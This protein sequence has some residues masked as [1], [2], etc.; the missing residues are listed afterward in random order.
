MVIRSS[1]FYLSAL[2]LWGQALD[3]LTPYPPYRTQLQQRG[4]VRDLSLREALETALAQNPDI[5]IENYNRELAGLSTTSA[6]S[7]YDPQVALNL[8]DI[9][10]NIPVTS[11]LQ[12]GSL[13][14]QITKS[15]SIAPS[16]QQD[17]PGGGAA[18]FTAN[19]TKSSNSSEYIFINPVFNSTL[20]V[21]L[22]Q[23]LAR[24]FRRT[25]AER[26]VVVSRINERMTESQFR[27]RVASVVEQVVQAYWKLAAAIEAHEAQRLGREVAVAQF[28]ETRKLQKPGEPPSADLT[29]QRADLVSREQ[30]VAQAG[31]QIG[32]ASNNLKRLLTRSILDPLWEVGLITSDRP[33]LGPPPMSV[34][35]A[36]S[37][38]IKTREDL[39]Q[40]RLHVSQSD[41][42][43]RYARQ[44][45][46][47]A[48]NLRVEFLSTGTAGRV[49]AISPDGVLSTTTLDPANP[50]Y[51]GI[52]KASSQALK[53]T[54]P[55]VA[56]GLEIRLP[57]GN[58]AAKAQ[59]AEAVVGGR[60]LNAQIRIAEED[61]MIEV[62][63]AREPLD[64]LRKNV[65]AASVSRKQ[66]EG[67]LA[68]DI[69]KAGNAPQSLDV[70][71]SQRDLADA[72]L[73]EMQTFIEYRKA[74]M[75]LAKATNPL[76]DDLQIVLARRKT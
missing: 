74:E 16:L 2:T 34:A 70:L 53:G 3:S 21:T 27:Q 47:P 6:L 43:V 9:S 10:S 48:V 68:A 57:V 11:T 38:A 59:L 51:G 36:V 65:E 40:L 46:K 63:N 17:L 7:H 4:D 73:H 72:R 28:E 67:K 33:E 76:V 52:A 44:E 45:T 60:K 19:L 23:P 50:L 54:H 58:H 15:W 49:Y 13:D 20:G 18:T 41:A 39:E 37:T 14:S 69:A 26:Q 71:R 1:L 25:Y 8:S 29:S 32:Q 56:A 24:G 62:R 30:A 64:T 66:A 61:I 35:E 55:S 75:S 12:T 31:V 42:E 22:T 5:E